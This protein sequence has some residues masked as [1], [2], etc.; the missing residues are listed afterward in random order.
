VWVVNN[1]EMSVLPY[2]FCSIVGCQSLNSKPPSRSLL[3]TDIQFE[4][5]WQTVLT[6]PKCHWHALYCRFFRTPRILNLI[7]LGLGQESLPNRFDPSFL[8][9]RFLFTG[10]CQAISAKSD[11][12]DRISLLSF[13]A[14]AGIFVLGSG[15]L[16]I[17]TRL[18]SLVST[19]EVRMLSWTRRWHWHCW[20]QAGS[21]IHPSSAV[22]GPRA[23]WL[24]MRFGVGRGRCELLSVQILS[25]DWPFLNSDSEA[26]VISMHAMYLIRGG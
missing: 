18:L 5:V 16:N 19:V 7:G 17:H 10:F 15:D 3:Q 12:L 8:P 4:S 11:S 14:A 23:G 9:F 24:D 22:R 6:Q 13:M 20:L 26:C 25:G 21:D 1:S 2:Y